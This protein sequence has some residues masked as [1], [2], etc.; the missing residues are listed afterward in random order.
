MNWAL[1]SPHAD[2]GGTQKEVLAN[3]DIADDSALLS[4]AVQQAQELLHRVEAESNKVGLGLN[5][6]QNQMPG[7]HHRQL[8]LGTELEQ[9]NDF[10]SNMEHGLKKS[11]FIATVE[12]ILVYGCESWALNESMEKSLHT[13]AT[14]DPKYTMEFVH[15][16]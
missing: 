15:I 4:E 14:Q 12:S 10:K 1:L 9:K 2:P 16:Q 6:P 13:H 8:P 3:L 11:F 5:G 7:L